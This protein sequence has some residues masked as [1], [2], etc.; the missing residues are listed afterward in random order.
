MQ[1]D[2]GG[3]VIGVDL[4]KDSAVLEAATTTRSASPRRSTATCCAT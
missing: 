3:L 4:V 2:G 1:A